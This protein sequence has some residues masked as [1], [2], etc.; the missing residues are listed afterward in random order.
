MVVMNCWMA[1]VAGCL[2]VIVGQASMA[3]SDWMVLVVGGLGCCVGVGNG[4]I[5]MVGVCLCWWLG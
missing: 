4:V 1:S 2:S 3:M 5:A